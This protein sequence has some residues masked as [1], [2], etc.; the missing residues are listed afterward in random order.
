MEYEI[1]MLL[2]VLNY[3]LLYQDLNMD[4]WDPLNHIGQPYLI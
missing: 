2:V 4:R 3:I 1:F